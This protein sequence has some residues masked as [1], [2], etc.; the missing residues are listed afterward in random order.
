MYSVMLK[1][2]VK[3]ILLSISHNENVFPFFRFILIVFFKCHSETLTFSFDDL[4]HNVIFM[5]LLLPKWQEI[6]FG[7]YSHL[8][9]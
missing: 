4:F 3:E 8:K 6:I 9:Y 2:Q 1:K 5:Y 7:L